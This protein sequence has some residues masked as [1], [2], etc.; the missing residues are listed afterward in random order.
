[1]T[2]MSG[3]GGRRVEM[4]HPIP[5]EVDWAEIAWSLAHIYRY[6]GHAGRPVSVAR[7]TLIMA[8]AAPPALIPHVL[9]HDAPESRLGDTVTPVK[10]TTLAC[11][12]ELFGEAGR[13]VFASVRRRLETRH[14][15]AIRLAAGLGEP[16]A[17]EVAALK[18]LDL[19]ALRAERDLFFFRP[20]PAPAWA[21]VIEQAKPLPVGGR[22]LKPDVPAETAQALLDA[23]HAY[24]PALRGRPAP[25]LTTYPEI[26]P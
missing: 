2:W 25:R 23:F 13:R 8:E 26:L 16:S 10:D 5:E 14:D 7:H 20:G 17:F 1:M 12:S 15:H 3:R 19:S 4:L 24:L 6:N 11:A 18:R 22:H 21:D 9:I